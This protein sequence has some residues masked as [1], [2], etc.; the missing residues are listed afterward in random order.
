[1]ARKKGVSTFI[2]QVAKESIKKQKRK[3]KESEQLEKRYKKELEKQQKEDYIKSN[4]GQDGW[5]TIFMRY[6]KYKNMP[7]LFNKYYS[8]LLP[9]NINHY[10]NTLE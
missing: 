8:F 3:S 4:I 5:E 2:N 1:M 9:K 6:I 10:L 7:Y